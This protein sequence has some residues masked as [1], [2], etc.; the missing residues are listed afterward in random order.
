MNLKLLQYINTFS[1]FSV[2][3]SLNAKEAIEDAEK[4]GTPDGIG[5]AGLPKAAGEPP[6]SKVVTEEPRVGDC[7]VARRVPSFHVARA[8]SKVV[9]GIGS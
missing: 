3:E 8:G 7:V 9:K 1:F 6:G 4:Y 2:V 5:G